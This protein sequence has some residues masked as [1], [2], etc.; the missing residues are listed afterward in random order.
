MNTLSYF[1]I[2]SSEPAR[3]IEFYKNVFGWLFSRDEQL[4]IE[5]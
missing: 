3:E 5:Y 1:E 4:P 2:Q